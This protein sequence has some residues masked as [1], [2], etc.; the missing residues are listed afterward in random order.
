M[1]AAGDLE[2]LSIR[3]RK[4]A[5]LGIPAHRWQAMLD[6]H[7]YVPEDWDELRQRHLA[8]PGA[9]L[10]PSGE[11]SRH[12]FGGTTLTMEPCGC[13][14]PIRQWFVIDLRALPNLAARLPGWD[15]F[16]LL[17]C[18]DCDA[19]I[20]RSDYQMTADGR[21][22]SLLNQRIP[23]SWSEIGRDGRP[24]ERWPELPRQW[25][26]L[27]PNQTIVNA[28]ADGDLPPEAPQVGGTPR[29]PTASSFRQRGQA[30]TLRCSNSVFHSAHRPAMHSLAFG[31]SR[32]RC[33]I[34]RRSSTD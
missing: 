31:N 5:R 11:E 2:M 34:P 16:P 1:L 19:S 25:A 4:V 15:L 14:H 8:D 7:R 17:S 9:R 21:G 10:V 27:E 28:D 33:W 23:G 3:Y 18:P 26:R 13:G 12:W 22:V 29:A 24:R 30:W 20:S 6:Q 32:S